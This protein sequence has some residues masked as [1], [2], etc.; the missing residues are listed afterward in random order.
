MRYPIKFFQ[1][2]TRYNPLLFQYLKNRWIW[3]GVDITK[4]K[5]IWKN[6]EAYSEPNI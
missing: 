5:N 3:T 4:E 6:S 1:N 2:E